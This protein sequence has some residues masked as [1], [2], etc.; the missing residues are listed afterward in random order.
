MYNWLIDFEATYSMTP[1]RQNYITFTIVD[2]IV[3]VA[4]EEVIV[5]ESYKDI[6]IN[7]KQDGKTTSILIKNV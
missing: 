3:R 7:L 6:L 4:N 5:V 2:I 1:Y